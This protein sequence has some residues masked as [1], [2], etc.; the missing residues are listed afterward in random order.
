MEKQ[1]PAILCRHSLHDRAV[2][3]RKARA[4]VDG[5]GARVGVGEIRKRDESALDADRSAVR[6]GSVGRMDV[7][8]REVEG[9]RGAVF[10]RDVSGSEGSCRSAV[11]DLKG[12][13]GDLRRSRVGILPG[14]DLRA[15]SAFLNG[16]ASRGGGSS[17]DRTGERSRPVVDAEDK[18]S[19]ITSSAGRD[20]PGSRKDVDHNAC[21]IG[22]STVPEI[23]RA[24]KEMSALFSVQSCWSHSPFRKVPSRIWICAPE[25]YANLT[26]LSAFS[27]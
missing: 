16:Y 3:D 14:E 11:A 6:D 10:D 7:P 20:F 26:R 22:S 19:R 17:N 18:K 9:E 27:A 8:R 24:V 1:D 5:N 25:S 15:G 12:S 13:A 4:G 21:R 23:Q 2:Q